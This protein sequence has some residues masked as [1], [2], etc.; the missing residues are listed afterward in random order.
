MALVRTSTCVRYRHPEFRLTY[1]PTVV[2]V[3][4]DVMRF[5]SWLED[6]V[7]QGTRYLAGQTCQVGWAVTEVRHC[8]NGDLS[9]WEPNMQHMPIVWSECVSYT[10]AHMRLQK[11]VVDS[12]LSA[13]DL[14]FPYM[15]E[16]ALI[17]TRLGQS[18]GL[19]LERSEPSGADSGWFCGC[20]DQDHD[21]DNPAEL[22]R[23][24]LYEAAVTR[25]W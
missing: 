19:L 10:L 12:I 11:D 21:H 22:R 4:G 6:S 17:C 7:A 3:E 8:E 25:L 15:C 13:E 18:E 24:S 14:S 23:V 9:L 2:H 5:I 20:R 16:S 1:D